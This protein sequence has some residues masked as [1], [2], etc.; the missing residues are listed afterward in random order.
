MRRFVASIFAMYLSHRR[1]NGEKLISPQMGFC[2]RSSRNLTPQLFTYE[3]DLKLC[4][5]ENVTQSERK[6][7]GPSPV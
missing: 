1:N 3:A 6:F 2:Y 7:Q 5:K 4:L